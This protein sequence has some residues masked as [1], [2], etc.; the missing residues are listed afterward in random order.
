MKQVLLALSL[1]S[2]GCALAY[3][4]TAISGTVT[5]QSG[6]ITANV[7][8]RLTPVAD[9]AALATISSDNGAYAFPSLQA[10][11]YKLRAEVP[12]FTSAERKINLLAASPPRWTVNSSQPLPP[13]RSM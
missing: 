4:Q 9:G 13:P 1:L 8:L 7:A 10:A 6:A 5:N 12:G 11:E 2:A 3:Q